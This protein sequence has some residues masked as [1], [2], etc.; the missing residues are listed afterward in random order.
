MSPAYLSDGVES[1]G[2]LLHGTR[3]KPHNKEVDVTLIWGDYYFV[4]AL[5]RYQSIVEINAVPT[6]GPIGILV[7][8]SL[9][10]L[11]GT[12]HAGRRRRLS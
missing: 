3:S 10:G 2:L 1:S 7:L 5:V 12:Y 11:L 6:A 4:E 9:F 8:V